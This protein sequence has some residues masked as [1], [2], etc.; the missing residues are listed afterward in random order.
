[1]QHLSSQ[2]FL[3]VHLHKGHM[4]SVWTANEI[5]ASTN[6][7]PAI[8]LASAALIMPSPEASRH[9]PAIKNFRP[10][11]TPHILSIHIIKPPGISSCTKVIKVHF[12][13][14]QNSL[15]FLQD[16][17]TSL[18][19]ASGYL[20]CLLFFGTEFI[21]LSWIQYIESSAARLTSSTGSLFFN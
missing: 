2:H 6:M 17:S 12:P 20:L 18:G 15:P 8:S 3:S 1:L 5:P 11:A 7:T 10:I 16:I 21:V 13:V 19:L 9:E 4:P 14:F